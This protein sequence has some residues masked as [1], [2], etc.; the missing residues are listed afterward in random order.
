MISLTT[1]ERGVVQ[2]KALTNIARLHLDQAQTALTAGDHG[3]VTASL[4]KADQGM[5]LLMDRVMR[6]GGSSTEAFGKESLVLNQADEGLASLG[7]VDLGGDATVAFQTIR[8]AQSKLGVA[9][10]ALGEL[11]AMARPFPLG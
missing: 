8:G 11:R 5:R 6:F 10:D 1:L 7:R 2:A 4:A 9:S 3:A